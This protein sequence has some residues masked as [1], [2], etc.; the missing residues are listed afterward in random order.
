MS[1]LSAIQ[2]SAGAL[3]TFG[4]ALSADQQNVANSATPGYAAVRALVLPLGSNLQGGSDRVV[5]SS[6]GDL[7]SDNQV[8]DSQTRSGASVATT[9]QLA[10]INQ[11]FDITGASGILAALQG[12]STAFS[13]ASVTPNDPTLRGIALSSAAAVSKAFNSVAASLDAQQKQIDS[14]TASTVAQINALGRKISSFNAQTQRNS[15]FDPAVDSQLR[16]SLD[17]LSTLVPINV[18]N[19]ADGTAAVLV[20]GRLPLVEGDQSFAISVN[21]SAPEGSQLSSSGGGASAVPVSGQ[22]GA[23]VGVRN[24]T[25]AS[26]IGGNGNIG[27]LNVL[28]KGFAARVNTL[29][30]SGVTPSGAVGTALYT[31]DQGNDANVARTLSVEPSVSNDRLAL[32]SA[33]AG[34]LSNGIA[35]QLAQLAGSSQPLDQIGGLSAQAFFSS[36]ASGVGQEYSDATQQSSTDQ[37]SVTAAVA[38]RKAVSGVSLDQE[39]VNITSL[40]R[41][42]EAAAKIVSVLDQLTN[43]EVNLIK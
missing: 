43:D 20:G 3:R 26:I 21:A 11:L 40:Q 36:I 2:T 7:G 14:A 32:A 35:N 13:N 10:Q 16:S 25:I 1:L 38:N 33:G 12:F 39:A 6:T 23:L 5:L 42:Y 28:A 19:N 4:Q 9:A 18:S 8:R 29:L 27:S 17:D 31:Y 24:Q 15:Q 41:A 30:T 37:S 22:L 34:G